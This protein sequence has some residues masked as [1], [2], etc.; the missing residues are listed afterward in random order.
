MFFLYAYV[1]LGSIILFAN[2]CENFDSA[3][4]HNITICDLV[5]SHGKTA[6]VWQSLL[7]QIAESFDTRIQARAASEK[8]SRRF[9]HRSRASR[10]CVTTCM[11]AGS[12]ALPRAMPK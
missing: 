11:Y 7:S 1:E 6:C 5:P 2:N 8:G 4:K 10:S 9:F 12:T 3:S